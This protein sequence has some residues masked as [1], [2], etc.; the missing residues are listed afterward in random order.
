MNRPAVLFLWLLYFTAYMEGHELLRLPLLI[1]HYVQHRNENPTMSLMDFLKMHYS[2]H[3]I[4]DA[5]WRQ[6]MQ[7][8]FKTVPSND[9]CLSALSFMIIPFW[10]NMHYILSP[11]DRI[12]DSIYPPRRLSTYRY[13]F[14][15]SI[16]KPPRPIA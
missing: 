11:E 2:G 4:Y 16:F 1:E 12:Q 3:I 6:D 8:P 10:K 15:S 13:D 14:W 9:L 5:D 7:L